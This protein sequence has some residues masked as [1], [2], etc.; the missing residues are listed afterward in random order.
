MMDAP[1]PVQP[2]QDLKAGFKPRQFFLGLCI[3]AII[4]LAVAGTRWFVK[5]RTVSAVSSCY[6]NLKQLQGA[7]DSWALNNHKRDEDL[8]KWTDLIGPNGYI[9]QMP[10]CPQGGT[11]SLGP[12]SEPVRCSVPDHVLP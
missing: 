8:P 11:Y 6:A 5:A 12:V 1:E 9:R 2:R 4:V 10:I 3:G 7:K